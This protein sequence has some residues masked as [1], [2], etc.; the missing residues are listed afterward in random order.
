MRVTLLSPSNAADGRVMENLAIFAARRCRTTK[1]LED[2][3]TEVM[4]YSD[5]KRE[6]FLTKV[7]VQDW[8]ADVLEMAHLVYDIEGVPVWLVIELLRHRMV[9]R[10]FSLE[11][12]SQRAIDGIK[13]KVEAPDPALQNLV[14]GYMAQIED[15]R[16]RLKIAPEDIREIY[17]QGVL[18]NFVIAGNLRAFHHFWWMR[19]SPLMQGKGGAHRKFQEIADEMYKQAQER[20]PALTKVLVKA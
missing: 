8:A 5:E 13:L 6:S 14:D 1:T 20:L 10:E 4:S 2:L 16:T 7:I 17:P 11:Q 15:A 19:N 3:S 9:A 12:L 18:V